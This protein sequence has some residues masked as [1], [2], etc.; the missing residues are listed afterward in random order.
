MGKDRPAS[1]T[2]PTAVPMPRIDTVA[3]V[4]AAHARDRGD[5][6][7]VV[8]GSARATFGEL[9]EQVRRC[10]AGLRALGVRPGTPVGLL[11]T[12]RVEWVVAALATITLGARVAAINTWSRRWDLDRL[13]RSS[14]CEVLVALGG[15]ASSRRSPVDPA[16]VLAE[17]VPEAWAATAPGW[18]SAAYPALRELVLVGDGPVP[19]GARPFAEL[20]VADPDPHP[21]AG[22]RDSVALVMYTSGSTAEPKAVALHQGPALEHG[23]DVGLRMGVLPTDRV[24]VPVPLFWS[25]GGANAMM[26]ALVHGACLV[27][28]EVFDAGAALEL[29]ATEACTVAYTLPN[30]TAALLDHP[31][32]APERVASLSR[33]MTIGPP[34]DVLAALDDLGVTG[35][36]NAYG[37]TE[38]Y[39]GAT[40]TP[41]DWPADRK[42]TGQGPALP[43]NTVTVCGPDGEPVVGELGEITVAGQVSTGYVG[44]PAESAAA[45]DATG[46]RTGDLG[47]LDPD[48]TLHFVARATEMI[49]S[50]GINIAPAEVEEFLRTHPDVVEAA[51]VGA[52][53]ERLGQVAVGFVTVRAG[54]EIDGPALRAYLRD[55]LASFKVPAVIAVD[56]AP[57]PTTDT[58]KL[59]RGALR[60]RAA[61]ALA[62]A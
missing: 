57:L 23:F 6:P 53:D 5:A 12:N 24:W 22:D 36:C 58:G 33:G 7:A 14:G 51:V 20:L 30:I 32:F 17:L 59:A 26:V 39:G 38:A 47:I 56:T 29:I 50:G 19:A 1:G 54:A 43:R 3:Q 52:P 25:Y 15:A 16:A 2:R 37:S 28:Q 41:H 61:K 18:A 42:A 44:R 31:A 55:N 11:C 9:D 10:A 13:L 27:L 40:V 46:F 8:A 49:K 45:F 62:D 48:G 21:A 34:R 35:I 4:L 60:D